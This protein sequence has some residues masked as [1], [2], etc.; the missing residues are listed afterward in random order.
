MQTTTTSHLFSLGCHRP[1]VSLCRYTLRGYTHTRVN[2]VVNRIAVLQKK[3]R[4]L[5]VLPQTPP[6]YEVPL[7]P[8]EP[9]YQ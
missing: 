4:E 8:T 3:D 9:T 5:H 2:I 7:N 1:A 6:N